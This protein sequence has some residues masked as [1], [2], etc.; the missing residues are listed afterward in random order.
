MKRAYERRLVKPSYSGEQQCFR[1]ASPRRRPP[2]T[3]AAV[4]YRHLKPRRQHMCYNGR[5]G[6]VTQALG[7]IQKIVS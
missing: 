2:R 4:E 5:A 6:E 7:G 1:D 3:A